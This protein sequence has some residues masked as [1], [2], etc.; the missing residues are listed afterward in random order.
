MQNMKNI[1]DDLDRQY[2]LFSSLVIKFI[3]TQRKIVGISLTNIIR[4]SYE[5]QG[6]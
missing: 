4:S 5:N 2:T 3:G 6:E 1:Q